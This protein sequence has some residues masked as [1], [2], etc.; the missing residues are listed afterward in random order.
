MSIKKMTFKEIEGIQGCIFKDY[1]KEL[2]TPNIKFIIC[3]ICGKVEETISL[4]LHY[5]LKHHV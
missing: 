1:G 2:H 3:P 4:N 5:A